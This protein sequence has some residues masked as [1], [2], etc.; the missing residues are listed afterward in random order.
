LIASHVIAIYKRLQAIHAI[1]FRSQS[2]PSMFIAIEPIKKNSTRSLYHREHLPTG[3][4][5]SRSTPAPSILAHDYD[6]LCSSWD[7]SL[8]GTLARSEMHFV[9]E[10]GI[11][12]GHEGGGE[13]Q[14]QDSTKMK[15]ARWLTCK[16]DLR[17]EI[18]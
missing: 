2:K 12:Y 17:Y 7:R 3:D 4:R 6:G 10:R 16:D 8:P 18:I 15:E 14:F 1:S 13:A 11:W 9:P 5:L